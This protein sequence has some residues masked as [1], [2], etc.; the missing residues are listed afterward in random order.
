MSGSSQGGPPPMMRRRRTAITRWSGV[1]EGD[2]FELLLYR[3][4]SKRNDVCASRRDLS[5]GS[6]HH[7]SW[8]RGGSWQGGGLYRGI[9]LSSAT[10]QSG[11]PIARS[12]GRCCICG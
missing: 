2:A 1:K 3:V 4:W 9:P 12:Y 6:T 8:Y 10:Q 11:L 5:G 7:G